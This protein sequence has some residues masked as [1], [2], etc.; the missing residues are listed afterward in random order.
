MHLINVKLKCSLFQYSSACCLINN[1]RFRSY[2]EQ[3]GESS[4]FKVMYETLTC[5][6]A[7]SD[8]VVCGAHCSQ[9][10]YDMVGTVTFSG[11]LSKS[12]SRINCAYDIIQEPGTYIKLKQESLTLPCENSAV[13]IRDGPHEN[14]PLMGRFCKENNHWPSNFSSSQNHVVI[15]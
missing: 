3:E 14:S 8:S 7:T 1:F 9:T 12:S 15:R 2:S 10:H 13:E 4:G 5:P 11:N 6:N